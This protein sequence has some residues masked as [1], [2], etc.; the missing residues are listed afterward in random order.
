MKLVHVSV[1]VTLVGRLFG[2]ANALMCTPEVCQRCCA[3]VAT[4]CAPAFQQTEQGFLV[5]DYTFCQECECDDPG[6]GCGWYS[7][8]FLAAFAQ[9]THPFLRLA[10]GTG[11]MQCSSCDFLRPVAR[12]FSTVLPQSHVTDK[13]LQKDFPVRRSLDAVPLLSM[14]RSCITTCRVRNY[15][16]PGK[17][18]S[19]LKND[20]RYNSSP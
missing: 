15:V 6:N 19:T 16:V 20:F 5:S 11:R 10:Y 9:N 1:T 8:H 18:V 13:M 4:G 3:P 12:E 17:S 2:V 7:T 14:D